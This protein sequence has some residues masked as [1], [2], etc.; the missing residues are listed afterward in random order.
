M[1]GA[2]EAV[3]WQPPEPPVQDDGSAALAGDPIQGAK[4]EASR[5]F[6]LPISAPFTSGFHL[7]LAHEK[8]TL[9]IAPMRWRLVESALLALMLT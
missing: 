6:F 4:H 5:P 8:R 3:E 9:A 1:P 7:L 2:P